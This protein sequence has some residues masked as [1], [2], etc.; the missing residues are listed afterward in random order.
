M[1]TL[2]Y[3]NVRL[4][5]HFVLLDFMYDRDTYTLGHPLRL[6]DIWTDEHAAMAAMLC[7]NLLEPL[8]SQFGPCSVAGGFWPAAVRTARGHHATTPHHWDYAHG[9][10]ADVSWH[11]WVNSGRAPIQLADAIDKGTRVPFER[12]ITYAGTEFMCMAVKE[13]PRYAIHENI[14]IPGAAHEYKTWGNGKA[15]RS[16]APLPERDDWRRDPGE[17]IHITNH[18]IRPHHVRVGRY[19]TLLDMCRNSRAI[20][21]GRNTVPPNTLKTVVDAARMVAEILDPLVEQFGRVTILRGCEPK[22]FAADDFAS[23]HRWQAEVSDRVRVDFLL[24]MD[25]DV[26]GA[27]DLLEADDRVLVLEAGDHPSGSTDVT[28]EFQRFEPAFRWTSATGDEGF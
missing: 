1:T 11:D 3:E 20:V 27:L 24:P 13:N 14:R 10:A 16:R 4:S 22:N 5:K 26:N 2:E 8:I 28:I 12:I 7:E 19:F 17:A 15:L 21:L 25:T 9:A 6:A 23:A 18:S